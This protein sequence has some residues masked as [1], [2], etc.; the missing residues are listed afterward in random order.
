MENPT[1]KPNFYSIVTEHIKK[2]ENIRDYFKNFDINKVETSE[3]QQA[4]LENFG[5][6]SFI[7]G[8]TNELL[9]NK[10]MGMLPE[11]SQ[12]DTNF[13]QPLKQRLEVCGLNDYVT[14]D[15]F[16]K[17]ML[18]LS[19]DIKQHT[20]KDG[21]DVNVNP[22][23]KKFFDL[24]QST[25]DIIT[26]RIVNF[27]ENDEVVA[28]VNRLLNSDTYTVSIEYAESL[29]AVKHRAGLG[30]IT[31]HDL[32]LVNSFVFEHFNITNLALI[33][34]IIVDM[35]EGQYAEELSK[36]MVMYEGQKHA[37]LYYES[38]VSLLETVSIFDEDSQ[39]IVKNLNNKQCSGYNIKNV[40]LNDITVDVET[41]EDS[42]VKQLKPVKKFNYNEFQVSQN[43]SIHV[44]LYKTLFNVGLSTVEESLN[45]ITETEI[46]DR[47]ENIIFEGIKILFDSE[48]K[49][50]M[51]NIIM[52]GFKSKPNS[53]EMYMWLK[54][55]S[56]LPK[57]TDD[58]KELN[59]EFDVNVKQYMSEIPENILDE[60]LI[61]INNLLS[62]LIIP[63]DATEIKGIV[64]EQFKENKIH[65]YKQ[66]NQFI[67]LIEKCTI[68]NKDINEFK[69]YD[70]FIK[71]DSN[72]ILDKL[73]LSVKLHELQNKSN[74]YLLVQK[75]LK[76]F[77]IGAR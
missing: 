58:L 43:D 25:K 65:T 19:K 6:M 75:Y 12:I 33:Q 32:I 70:E 8:N 1:G 59:A 74:Y 44:Y 40:K 9:R 17:S 56:L 30:T 22:T 66:L 41:E 34:P 50:E 52:N 62:N 36:A 37:L 5:S 57:I 15:V 53:K 68:S 71:D 77:T 28:D 72:A 61:K 7:Y 23:T 60:L 63:S 20:F 31:Y 13:K 69:F 10:A 39:I 35:Y 73:Q 16:M 27:V 2:Q 64:F 49:E 24:L 42:K 46:P 29:L 55:K 3:D 26:K 54:C 67:E 18:K 48:H 21:E 4:L 47:V 38:F 76:M 45:D 11:M 51:Q 14:I